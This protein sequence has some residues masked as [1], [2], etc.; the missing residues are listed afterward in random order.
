MALRL[1]LTA[2]FRCFFLPLRQIFIFSEN[3]VHG[4]S[5]LA[6][7]MCMYPGSALV[8]TLHSEA[9]DNSYGLSILPQHGTGAGRPAG[10]ARSTAKAQAASASSAAMPASGGGTHSPAGCLPD[11]VCHTAGGNAGSHSFRTGGADGGADAPGG[12]GAGT[13]IHG[14]T[15]G[16]DCRHL[17]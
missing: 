5:F 3:R 13:G 8:A 11:L 17:R 4:R 2:F 16:T 1:G 10:T 7:I 15:N 14:K 12:A 6:I 9:G